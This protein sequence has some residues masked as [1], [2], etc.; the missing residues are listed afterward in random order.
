LCAEQAAVVALGQA[1]GNEVGL[2]QEADA[3]ADVAGGEVGLGCGVVRTDLEMSE[4]DKRL[5]TP[6]D[7]Q[8]ELVPVVSI[9]TADA[10]ARV[11]RG[12]LSNMC[13]SISRTK[14]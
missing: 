13:Q 14:Y 11:G 12:A 1:L 3:E 5:T 9:P 2:V 10:L 7:V 8:V 6:V 4:S